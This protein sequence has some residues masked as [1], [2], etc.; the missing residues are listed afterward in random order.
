[1]KKILPIVLCLLFFACKDE[2]IPVVSVEMLPS[3][4]VYLSPDTVFDTIRYSF[5]RILRDTL[6]YD[7]I[8]VDSTSVDTL[9]IELVQVDTL[10]IDTFYVD[11]FFIDTVRLNAHIAYNG[12]KPFAPAL[13]E[14]GFCTNDSTRFIVAQ[15]N[16]QAT[17]SSRYGNFSY[18][19][20]VR[21]TDTLFVYAYARNP[22]GEIRSSW[23]SLLVPALDNR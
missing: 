8:H 20:P 2:P 13:H 1:M 11:T 4:L 9:H 15:S 14:L 6:R 21:N 10:L 22:F 17:D 19:L 7:S 5:D 18:L 16:D 23:A 3:E 12:D